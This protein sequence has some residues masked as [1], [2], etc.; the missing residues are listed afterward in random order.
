[1]AEIRTLYWQENRL[2]LLDQNRLPQEITYRVCA[3]YEEVAR[4]IEEMTV[5]G[6]PAIGVAAAFGVV[7]A[8][9]E[10]ATHGRPPAATVERALERL[11][12]TRPTAVNLFWAL[13]RM[14]RRWQEVRHTA[15]AAVAAAL[16]AEALA[17][18]RE[19]EEANRRLAQFGKELVPYG[20][21]V[22]T[23]C[24]AGALATV[25]YGTALGVLRAAHEEGRLKMVYA[26]ET[27]PRL[28]G[29]RLTAW[30]LT[31]LG[32]PVTVLCDN[33]AAYLMA[34]QK[35]DLVIVGADRIVANG[36]VANKIGT[37]GLA[38]AAHYHGVPFY[39]A[40]PTSTVDLQVASGKAIPIEQRAEEEVRLWEGKPLVP[41][42]ARVFNPA[43]D[44]TPAALISAIITEKG[45][46]RPPF[47]AALR[48]LG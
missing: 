19:E 35:I 18:Y 6:A 34:Q 14:R 28:Q 30:E 39:V 43:F 47:E 41:A 13:A 44:V 26:D 24:N 32:I 1:M 29:A 16:E 27:R 45:I 23:H 33:M 22:L 8:A 7:L 11:G 10:A 48:T 12:A 5:R 20:A 31:T 36:D 15:P 46:L 3:S 2:F 21:R 40:A 38:V 42:A 37:Y 9:V 25:G 17:I 4:A